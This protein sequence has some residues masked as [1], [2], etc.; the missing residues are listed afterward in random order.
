MNC[1]AFVEEI[2][3]ATE[4]EAAADLLSCKSRSDHL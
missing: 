4:V 3:R 1:A 2:F